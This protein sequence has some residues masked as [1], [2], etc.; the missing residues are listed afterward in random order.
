V[1]QI[2]GPLSINDGAATPVAKSFAPERVAPELSTFTERTA[3]SS[4]GFLRLGV[5][6]SAASSKRSTNRVD[7]SFDYPV[8]QSVNGV[9]SV[10]YTAR[11]K[12]QFVIPDVMTAAER[13]NL[14]AFVANAMSN[15][16]VK[17][18]VKDLDPM[19]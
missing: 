15:A 16:A 8:L 2:T 9:N 1:S 7:I 13:A 10:A 12:G 14:Q 5:S 18:V 11:F 4:A 19:Y 3:A 6:Y 17:A